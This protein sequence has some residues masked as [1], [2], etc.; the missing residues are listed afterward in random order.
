MRG[1]VLVV[2][3]GMAAAAMILGSPSRA[4]GA[5]KP[6]KIALVDLNR[7]VGECQM[8]KDRVKELEASFKEKNAEIEKQKDDINNLGEE[9]KL[10]D[11]TSEEASHKRRVYTEKAAL[12]KAQATLA[13]MEWREKHAAAH[14][15]VYTE[16]FKVLETF[17]KDNGYD[18]L[19]RK[20][21]MDVGDLDPL[22]L[23][24]LLRRNTVLCSAPELDVT[25][26]IV[27]L[28]DAAY[29]KEK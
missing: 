18:L 8:G 27:K 9:L 12:L 10:L 17:R 29:T 6:M 5:D 25:D 13:T 26:Q 11:E 1:R 14:K 15:S 22:R 3:L 21:A 2:A 23:T 19:L 28:L 20:D 4:I 7:V 24:D 16:I